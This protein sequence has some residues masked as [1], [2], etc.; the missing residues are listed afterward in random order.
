MS[1]VAIRP[2]RGLDE[3]PDMAAANDRMRRHI[4]LLE[5]VDATTMA[6][7]Y[8][9]LVNS[10]PLQD[11]LI[12]ERGGETVGYA[13]VE[14]HDLRD[15]DRLLDITLVVA[16]EEWESDVAGRLVAWSEG[17]LA[18]IAAGL[19]AR[20][21]WFALYGFGGDAATETVARARGYDAVRWEAEMLRDDLLDL[22]ELTIANGYHLRSPE[23]AE[24]PAVFD[25][26]V[27]GFA[28]AW[29]QYEDGEHRFDAWVED[30]DF[31]RELAVVAWHGDVPVA[32]VLGE[33]HE[34][35]DGS[36][37]GLLA[38]VCTHPDHRR[39][40]LATAAIAECLR[41]LRDAGA[42]SAYLAADTGSEH[43]TLALYEGCGFRVA[44]RS[45]AYR[46][47]HPGRIA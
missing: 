31:R 26:L 17:R 29:G 37:R 40:G 47:P 44:T 5:G 33:L 2:Y 21:S 10:D 25:V 9:H 43:Q 15:G 8:T 7:R 45:T 13:R 35:A 12:A 28:D 20:R 11:C 3:I 34:Q 18:G 27:S 41:R 46:K 42:T 23:G 32:C 36:V 22:P 19:P 24:L 1:G 38:A 4:G 39:R 14:W 30:P 6:H 16:P